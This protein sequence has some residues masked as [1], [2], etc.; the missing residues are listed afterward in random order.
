L[1]GRGKEY[2][3]LNWHDQTFNLHMNRVALSIVIGGI[4]FL[5]LLPSCRKPTPKAAIPQPNLSILPAS[6][7]APDTIRR[8]VFNVGIAIL[9]NDIDSVCNYS[10]FSEAYQN[11]SSFIRVERNTLREVLEMREP[12]DTLFPDADTIRAICEMLTKRSIAASGPD[13]DA[14]A[15][16]D[17]MAH[18]INSSG[19]SIYIGYRT[20]VDEDYSKGSRECDSIRVSPLL[21][22]D[23]SRSKDVILQLEWLGLDTLGL[24]GLHAIA[25]ELSLP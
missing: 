19:L 18:F 23:L 15:H 2:Q 8:W 7:S 21:F 13:G 16:L 4:L 22:V 20:E 3:T 1:G 12:R 5:I 11:G 9:S 10:G 6:N 24:P 25:N 14:Y 17:S